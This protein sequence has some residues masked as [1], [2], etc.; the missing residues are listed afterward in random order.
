MKLGLEAQEAKGQVNKED[1]VSRL[2]EHRKFQSALTLKAFLDSFESPET[3]NMPMTLCSDAATALVESIKSEE[4]IKV[5]SVMIRCTVQAKYLGIKQIASISCILMTSPR[6]WLSQVIHRSMFAE[7][8][9]LKTA[10]GNKQPTLKG[11]CKY[12]S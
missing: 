4:Y 3:I 5:L 12:S 8:N 6:L 9:S 7:M 1:Q 11:L 10:V 2:S